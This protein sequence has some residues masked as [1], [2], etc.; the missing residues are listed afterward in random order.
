MTV[1]GIQHQDSH[2]DCHRLWVDIPLLTTL[3][4][5]LVP[6]TDSRDQLRRLVLV[7]F[8]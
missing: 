1:L 3:E 7:S 6:E 5:F 4:L 2:Q 8:I